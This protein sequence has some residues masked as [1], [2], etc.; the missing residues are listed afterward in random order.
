MPDVSVV[1]PTHDRR[2]ML[3]QAIGSVLAQQ[4]ASLEVVVVVDGS[5]DDTRSRVEALADTRIRLLAND[6]SQGVA[7]AR[8]QGIAHAGGTW[9]AFLDDDDLWA[10]DKLSRQLAAARDSGR[11]WAY[12]GAVAVDESLGLLSGEPPPSAERAVAELPFRNVI[13]AGSSN[14]LVRKDLVEAVGSFDPKL[15]HM[16]DWDLWIRLGLQGPPAVVPRAL[17]AYRVHGGNASVDTP[18]IP[19]EMRLIEERYAS[20]RGGAPIDRAYVHRWIAWSRLRVGDRKGALAAYL[21]ACRAGDLAS[22]AR[23]AVALVDPGVVGRWGP[24]RQSGRAWRM[25]AEEWLPKTAGR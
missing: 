19:E 20:A 9:I 18:A 4:D 16:A 12:A 15:R 5:K 13:P 21:R 6:R 10:P 3:L 7:V 24:S 22:L 2:E 1:V 25:Q 17:V 14:V 8:N 23:G 11:S